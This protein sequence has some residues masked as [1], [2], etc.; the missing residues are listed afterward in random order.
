MGPP[1]SHVTVSS[2]FISAWECITS[3]IRERFADR[4]A[5]PE[6]AYVS[7][8]DIPNLGNYF[9]ASSYQPLITIATPFRLS[10]IKRELRSSVWRQTKHGI[11]WRQGFWL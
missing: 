8:R 4:A 3:L 7:I 2:R 5:P 6:L 9:S 10:D 1:H 11:G